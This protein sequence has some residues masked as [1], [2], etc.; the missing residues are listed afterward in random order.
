MRFHLPHLMA[1][2]L[3]AGSASAQT[4]DLTVQPYAAIVARNMFGLVA[5]PP[6]P[7]PVVETPDIPKITP[8]GIMNIFG[9]LQVLFKVA[10]KGK[11]GQPGAEDAYTMTEGERQEEIEVVKIDEKAGVVT[12]NNHGTV[13]E[14]ALEVAKNGSTGAAPA[15]GPGMGRFG[16]GGI[17]P[18]SLRPNMGG[19][20]APVANRMSGFQ[21]GSNPGPNNLGSSAG[22]LNST[23]QKG[24]EL[25]PEAE[26]I[27]IEANRVMTQEAVD[28]G[29]MPPLPP[30]VMTPADATAAGGSPLFVPPVTTKKTK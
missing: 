11:P 24:E 4:A 10:S 27:A 3:L 17:S 21:T 5:I 2:L 12:F 26:V 14:L 18:A 8:N 6:P 16:G 28:K 7:P 29:F 25:S 22:G 15:G 20:P 30:T 9:Q 23:Q 19:I 13:Q 1:T